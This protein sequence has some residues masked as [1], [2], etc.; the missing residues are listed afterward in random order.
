MKENIKRVAAVVPAYN[1]EQRIAVVLAAIKQAKL[2]YQIVVVSDGSADKTYEVAASAPGVQA[3]RL[4][5]NVG[6][7]GAMR[8]GAAAADADILLFLDAD[9]IGLKPGQ[10]DDLIRPVLSGDVDMAVGVFRAG[11]S[12]TDLAQILVPYISG[13]RV[14]LR[15]TFLSIPEIEGVRS[16]VEVAITKYC[17]FR[18]MTVKNVVLAGVTHSMKEEKIGLIHG[19]AAR[20]RMYYDIGRVMTNGH[21]IVN[22]AKQAKSAFLASNKRD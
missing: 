14:M 13:Q 7:G 5:R 15:D 16:G 10:I 22:A 21:A 2:V 8:A 18:G 1:E 9:L 6:K 11:R 20:L 17:K 3:I 4:E 12:M 19:F